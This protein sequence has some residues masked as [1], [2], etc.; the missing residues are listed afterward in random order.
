MNWRPISEAPKDGTRFH[1]RVGDDAI[2]MLWHEGFGEFVSEWRRMTMASGY[3][4][5]GQAYKDHSP[6]IHHPTHWMPLP[7]PPKE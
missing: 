7:E 4:I 1:G 6:T 2:A 3:T 5:D